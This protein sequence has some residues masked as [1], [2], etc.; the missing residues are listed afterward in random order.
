MTHYKSWAEQPFYL[1]AKKWD[2]NCTYCEMDFLEAIL[3]FR[4]MP[5]QEALESENYIIKVLAIMDRRVGKRTLS[6]ILEEATYNDFPSW[7]RQFYDLRL[8]L[9]D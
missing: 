6:R 3:Q 4:N 7:V 9:T 5:I 8:S 2:A 1:M